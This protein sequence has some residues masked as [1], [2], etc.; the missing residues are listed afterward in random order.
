MDIWVFLSPL[1]ADWGRKGPGWLSGTISPAV[2]ISD[3]AARPSNPGEELGTWPQGT[4]SLP[5]TLVLSR[6]KGSNQQKELR[7]GKGTRQLGIYPRQA[8]WGRP[9]REERGKELAAM[10]EPQ[11]GLEP[12]EFFLPGIMQEVQ[13]KVTEGLGALD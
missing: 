5:P 1:T 9:T 6:R 7:N 10:S 2:R 8:G 12:G 4:C 13:G 3:L 11:I